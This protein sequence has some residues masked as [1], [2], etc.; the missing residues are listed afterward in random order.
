MSLLCV[1]TY[2]LYLT[3]TLSTTTKQQQQQH[4]DLQ[5]DENAFDFAPSIISIQVT[6]ANNRVMDTKHHHAPIRDRLKK[7]QEQ[8]QHS[9]T[10]TI[11]HTMEVDGMA[12]LCIAAPIL[13]KQQLQRHARRAGGGGAG[14]PLYRFGIRVMTEEEEPK[15]GDDDTSQE[16]LQQG[17]EP[18]ATTKIN[19]HLSNMETEMQRI[20]VSLKTVLREA[21]FAKDRD[22]AM[23]KQFLQMHST[24]FY[25]PIVQVCVLLVTGFTQAS[26]IVQFFK[27]RRII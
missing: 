22:A 11:R 18:E 10:G 20:L 26:H 24:T 16:Q 2:E 5:L 9:T 17:A 23:H 7:T 14:E 13:S 3:L 19:V 1:S 15:G 4:T 8:I 25:W 6:T 27:T 12:S 21:D